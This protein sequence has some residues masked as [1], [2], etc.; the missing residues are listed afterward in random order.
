MRNIEIIEG[1]ITAADVDAIVNAANPMMLGGDGVDG[2]IHRAAGPKLLEECQKV[3]AVN[4][5]RCPV[6]EA[7]IT[8]AGD[9]PSK[10]VI[11]AVGPK[12]HREANP[13]D[14]L[15]RAYINSL[16]LGLE[17]QCE[18]IAFPAI[19]CGAYGYPVREAAEIAIKIC[20]DVKFNAIEVFFY[21]YGQKNYDIWQS[22]L[23][24]KNT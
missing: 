7:R 18:S 5:V 8:L 14:L 4:K 2:A 17:Y 20:Q 13:G 6:G 1:D 11:H 21:L 12:Y 24:S 3:A 22:V 10:Y 16:A 19:S 9:L 23:D 15:A